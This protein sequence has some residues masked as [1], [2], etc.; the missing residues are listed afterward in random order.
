MS[1]G[2][3]TFVVKPTESMEYTNKMTVVPESQTIGGQ[4]RSN[5][6]RIRNR[7]FEKLSKILKIVLKLADV[8]GYDVIG[9][10]KSRDGNYV[11]NSSLIDLI[12]YA[13]SY[14]K[15][16]TGEKEFIDLLHDANI[17]PELIVN[18]NVK[19]KLL[20]LYQQ[21][22][23]Q[24]EIPASL[25]SSRP[26]ITSTRRLTVPSADEPIMPTI[27][28]T[29]YS[30]RQVVKRKRSDDDDVEVHQTVSSEPPIEEPAKKKVAVEPKLTSF[31]PK[32]TANPAIQWIYP[33]DPIDAIRREGSKD[34]QKVT[35]KRKEEKQKSL[36][37]R[38]GIDEDIADD[39]EEEV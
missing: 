21:S 2:S 17:T 28:N 23:R 24:E 5:E 15:A 9:R 19:Q 25:T 30:T 14:G 34:K 16:L 6:K 22:T 35:E 11:N 12:L 13:M 18:E 33:P 26:I 32:L 10:V 7:P 38:R 29:D 3:S 37:E 27:T 1:Q 20:M 8:K 39:S 31:T 4:E 36:F